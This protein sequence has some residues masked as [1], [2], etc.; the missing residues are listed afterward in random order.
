MSTLYNTYLSLKKIN[1]QTIYL[2]K[3]GIFLIAIDKDAN[4]LSDIFKFK[5]SNL[6]NTIAKCG[7][8]VSSFDKYSKLFKL[9]NLDVKVID[10]KMKTSY[11]LNEYRQNQDIVKIIELI[12]S[13]DIDNLSV[14]EAYKF[15]ETLKNKAL[16][17]NI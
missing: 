2:F 7:F 10:C 14:L 15:I 8:P 4:I 12:S 5:L 9:Y 16:N 1:S 13:V 17:L 11:K 3:S 6:T